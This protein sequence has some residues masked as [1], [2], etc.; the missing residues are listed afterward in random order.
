MN[1]IADA[2][3]QYSYSPTINVYIVWILGAYLIYKLQ[4]LFNIQYKTSDDLSDS[5][6][7]QY[8]SLVKNGNFK[9]WQVRL[10]QLLATPGL[11]VFNDFIFLWIGGPAIVV[12]SKLWWGQF[13]SMDTILSIFNEFVS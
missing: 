9:K 7:E 8:E 10:C 11:G 4:I 6:K 1:E 2:L 5:E 3:L 12:Y 13:L